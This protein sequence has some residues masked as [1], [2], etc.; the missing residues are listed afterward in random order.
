MDIEIDQTM[1]S[2]VDSK[3]FQ[4]YTSSPN[5][6]FNG[7]NSN[8]SVIRNESD[9][10]PFYLQIFSAPI[11]LL[12]WIFSFRWYV[13]LIIIIL[14]FYLVFQMQYA[15][16]ER[17]NKHKLKKEGMNTDTDE[18]ENN[19][20]NAKHVTFASD[21]E[22]KSSNSYAEDSN[23]KPII[24]KTNIFSDTYN[25]WITPWIYTVFRNI[26]ISSK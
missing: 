18:D 14:F 9:T 17:R 6:S 4:F 1:P 10:K 16:E 25:N 15:F 19:D 8:E 7:G 23:T 22:D 11:A 24:K 12:T 21:A 26:G 2:D 13:T 5:A 20:S 3:S